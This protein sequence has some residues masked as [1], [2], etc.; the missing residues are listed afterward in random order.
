MRK[1]TGRYRIYSIPG[2]TASL[3]SEFP[4]KDLPSA[5]LQPRF[6]RLQRRTCPQAEHSDDDDDDDD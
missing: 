6:L 5:E 2:K 4:V 3:V 1:G